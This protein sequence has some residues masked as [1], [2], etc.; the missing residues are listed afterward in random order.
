MT[1]VG[2]WLMP[3]IISLH[4]HFWRFLGVWALYTLG[5]GYLLYLVM[6]K[7]TDHSVPRKVYTWFLGVYRVSVAFG[8][9]GYIMLL[10][11]AFGAGAA[12]TACGRSAR[13]LAACMLPAVGHSCLAAGPWPSALCPWLQCH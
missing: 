8:M 4:L 9:L 7:R 13:C 12:I 10:T 3:A 11:S 2:L 5:T 1:L 6:H